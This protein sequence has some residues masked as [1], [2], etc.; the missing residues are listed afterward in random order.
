MPA[1]LDA[2]DYQ[3]WLDP[4]NKRAGELLKPAPDSA[5]AAT[6]ISTRVNSVANDD[7]AVIEPAAIPAAPAPVTKPAGDT[8][9]KLPSRQRSL[10]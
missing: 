9:A 5:L 6:P 3:A 10:F 4:D 8:S 1:I 2:R 7:P